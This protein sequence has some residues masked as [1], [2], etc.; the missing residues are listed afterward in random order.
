MTLNNTHLYICLDKRVSLIS[1]TDWIGMINNQNAGYGK[2]QVYGVASYYPRL[3][4]SSWLGHA[5]YRMKQIC[6]KE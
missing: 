6:M 4:K 1:I 5:E 2:S 3:A